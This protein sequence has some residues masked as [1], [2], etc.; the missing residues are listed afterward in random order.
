MGEC[1]YRRYCIFKN[2]DWVD[3]LDFV[4]YTLWNMALERLYHIFDKCC[5]LILFVS[6]SH[7]T[8]DSWDSLSSRC[9]IHHYRD[10]N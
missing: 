3:A 4:S 5:I 7:R 2:L 6:P 9:H 1:L 8:D 10:K